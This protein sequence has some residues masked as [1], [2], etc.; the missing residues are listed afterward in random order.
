MR[1]SASLIRDIE[2]MNRAV[3]LIARELSQNSRS[4]LT[5]RFLAKK[6]ELPQEEIEYL[7]DINHKLLYT[8]ITKIKLPAEGLTAIKRI[9]DG[10]ENLGDVPSLH[11]QIKG[12]SSQNFRLLEEHL[13]ITDLG[14]KK[15]VAEYILNEFYG[16][17]EAVVEY[18]ASHNFSD[19]AREVFDI[20]WQSKDGVMPVEK[21]RSGYDGTDYEVEQGL[22]ELFRGMALFEMFRFDAEDR[23]ARMAGILTEIRQWRKV[24]KRAF[25]KKVVLK[26]HKKVLG[27]IHA[28]GLEMTE[29]LCHLISAIAAKAVRLRGDGDLFREDLRRLSDTV[30]DE[31]EPSLSTCLWAAEGVGWLE[32]SGNELRAGELEA[33]IEK[34][35]FARHRQL[36]DWM[37]SAGNEGLIKRLLAELTSHMKPG[38]WYVMDDFVDFALRIHAQ[39]EPSTLKH[40]GGEYSYVN[41]VAAGNLEKNLTRSLEET[42]YWLGVVE[43]VSDG[44]ENYIRISDLGRSLLTGENGD[45]IKEQFKKHSQEI[46]V[47]PNFDI[48]VPTQDMDALLTVP[49]DQFAQRQSTGK[50]TVYLLT[51]ES[52]TQALQFGHDG[53]AFV[54]FLLAHNRGGTLPP[55][56]MTTL[57]DWRGGLRRVR[58]RT[59][60]LVEADDPLVMADLQHRRKFK[61]FLTPIDPHSTTGFKESDRDEFI[62]QLE[63]DGFI[64]E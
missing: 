28:R 63:K 49:L 52:F 18:V 64:V 7:V 41:P 33:L 43:H 54:E 6:L 19:T 58:F 31:A 57:D 5:V 30:R 36:F 32:R 61:K 23:L 21:I 38:A 60:E 59:V 22:L 35:F 13:Q 51:K 34:D 26:T 44:S 14:S 42:F 4:G 2:G 47:Q 50:A 53:D 20:I 62:K 46:I 3:Y 27:D 37:V 9:A 16:H 8:D 17:P 39:N 40:S 24:D 29:T 25:N 56:V 10:L 55:N 12:L 15:A 11:R 45:T 1:H 48:V